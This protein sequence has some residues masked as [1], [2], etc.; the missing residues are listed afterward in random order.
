[1]TF[2]PTLTAFLALISWSEGADYDTIV[3][4]VD[5]PATFSDFSDHPFA[6]QFNR[7]PV[8]VRRSPLLESTAAGRYQLLY[9]YWRVYKGQLGLSDYSPASQDAVAIEQMKER[10]AIA[11]IGTGDIEGAIRACGSIWASFPN[12]NYG[13]GGKTMGEL[14]TKFAELSG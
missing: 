3:T 7:P 5:G 11:L 12:N 9:R 6:P 8:I 2:S 14:L 4:G 1:M 10:G 13:Q